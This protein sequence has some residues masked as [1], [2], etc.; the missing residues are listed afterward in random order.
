MAEAN[1]VGY[2]SLP[3]GDEE[4]LKVAVDTVGPIAIG[5]L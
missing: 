1:V 5:N 2:V 4:L 3:A